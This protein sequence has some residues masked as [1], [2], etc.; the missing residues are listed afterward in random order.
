MKKN[1]IYSF[2]LC[3]AAMMLSLSAMAQTTV[4]GTVVD[5]AG[6]PVIGATVIVK[7]TTIGTTTG[8][9][10]DFQL[11]VPA[12]G[13]MEVSFLGYVSQEVENLNN[14]KVVLIEDKQQIEEVV[15]VGYGTQKKAHLT[16]SVAA[17]PMDE[18]QDISTG[19]LGTAL[20]GLINGISVS[21]GV[22]PVR[23]RL[24]RSMC[25]T[26]T[27]RSRRLSLLCM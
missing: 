5:E 15:V 2:C 6:Q 14:P 22:R 21:G 11:P 12:K 27:S 1:F 7:G 16:G 10:G 19:S 8:V 18:I 13:V 9:D 4:K 26:T 20:S 23:V 17:V 3:L 25:V 24:L